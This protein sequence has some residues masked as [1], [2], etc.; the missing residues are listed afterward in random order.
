MPAGRWNAFVAAV[1][2]TVGLATSD[3]WAVAP[4]RNHWN[5]V[6]EDSFVIYGPLDVTSEAGAKAGLRLLRARLANLATQ[7]GQETIGLSVGESELIE[8]Y[9]LPE[10]REPAFIG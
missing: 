6:P 2:Q 3:L 9:G 4:H 10:I 1:R 8:S 7:Y 5:A